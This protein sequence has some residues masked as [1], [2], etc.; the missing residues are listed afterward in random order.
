V[1]LRQLQYFVHVA[2]MQHV[3]KAAEELH[4]AQSAVSRQ[5]H[6]LEEELGVRLFMQ[7]GRNVQLTPVGQ[8]FLKRAEEILQDLD[9]AVNEIHEF[10]D[11]E[12][13]EIR[14]GF[15]HSLGTHLIPKVIASFRKKHPNVKFRFRQ[16][17][18]PSL[19]RDVVEAEVDL[20]FISPMPDKSDRV[21][22]EVILTESLCAILP[23]D[24]PL[25]SEEYIDLN[26]L[27]DDTFVLFSQ[28]YSLRPIVWEACRNAGFLPKIGFEGE[29]TDTIRGFVAA[30]MGVSLLPEMALSLQSSFM[31]AIVKIREPNVTRTIALIRRAGEKPSTVVKL[32][33]DYLIDYFRN[34]YQPS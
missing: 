2:R 23:K 1:E 5:I 21:E 14:L 17:M 22:G 8:L 18:Y 25:A 9:R 29:E 12:V 24:H 26:Q 32:F 31:P 30:G 28:G 6:R 34:V 11:P 7:R 16:G 33:H 15:P 3:T 19:I 27:K 20:A 4:V 13:G 10:L